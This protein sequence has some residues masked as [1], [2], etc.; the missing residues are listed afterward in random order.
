MTVK[1]NKTGKITHYVDKVTP[2]SNIKRTIITS[3]I[4]IEELL[5][6]ND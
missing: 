1:K 3:L 2:K 6:L 4:I 5:S